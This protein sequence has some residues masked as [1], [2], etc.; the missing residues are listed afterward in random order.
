M[1]SRIGC[2]GA[3]S[4]HVVEPTQIESLTQ[5]EHKDNRT[6]TPNNSLSHYYLV[7]CNHQPILILLSY[8]HHLRA[9]K[10]EKSKLI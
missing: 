3:S 10:S 4:K 8:K 2:Y 7:R 6:N 9:I 5:N 1:T